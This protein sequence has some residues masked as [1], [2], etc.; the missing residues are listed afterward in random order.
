MPRTVYDI[1][2]TLT[3]SEVWAIISKFL[4]EN[5]FNK[6]TFFGEELYELEL[7]KHLLVRLLSLRPR[8]PQAYRVKISIGN[9][10]LHLEFYRYYSG[11]EFKPGDMLDA[12]GRELLQKLQPLLAQIASN[13]P[14]SGFFAE[15]LQQAPVHQ[16]L[17]ERQD[18][19]APQKQKEHKKRNG[20]AVASMILGILAILVIPLI[21][22][23]IVIGIVGLALGLV[24]LS[25]KRAGRGMAAA[26]VVLSILGIGLE[27]LFILYLY[28]IR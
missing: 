8:P 6:T 1:P 27:I 17:M 3:D 20:F 25:K 19:I 18:S 7:K 10:I 23:S 2:T 22:L 24:S 28:S 15:T 13:Q 5:R 26:G 14:G 9:G 4:L 21:A 16:Q 11:W 12:Y